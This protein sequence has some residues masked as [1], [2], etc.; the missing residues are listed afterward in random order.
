MGHWIKWFVLVLVRP[1]LIFVIY[2]YGAPPIIK[3]LGKAI[4]TVIKALR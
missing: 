3:E 4:A 1:L 2:I